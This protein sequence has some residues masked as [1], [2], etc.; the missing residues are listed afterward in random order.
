MNNSINAK[1][2]RIKVNS[3]LTDPVIRR[4]RKIYPSL[5]I[6][7]KWLQEIGFKPG[8]LVTITE[9]TNRVIISK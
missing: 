1:Q 5:I 3:F 2:R 7:G 4:D 8:D 6:K 9:E